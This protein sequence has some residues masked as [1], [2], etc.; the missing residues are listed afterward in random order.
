MPETRTIDK[1]FL[2]L[3]QFTT[4]QTAREL[5]LECRLR[6]AHPGANRALLAIHALMDG[7]E[8][9]SDTLD[10]IAEILQEQGLPIREPQ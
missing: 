1:L 5:E 2:E 8:W 6:D 10:R 7:K 3:S 4:A 9:D